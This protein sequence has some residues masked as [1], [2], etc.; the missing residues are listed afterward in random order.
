VLLDRLIQWDKQL[1]LAV[2][3]LHA[4]W[5]D[6]VMFLISNMVFWLPLYFLLIY[7]L[8]RAFRHKAWIILIGLVITLLLCNLLTGELIKPLFA[9]LRPSH[10]PSLVGMVHLVRGYTGGL[11]GFSSGHAANTVAAAVFVWWSLRVRYPWLGL[12]FV[13]P[14]LVCYSRV[15]LGVHYPSDILA[16]GLLGL[17]SA[18][19]GLV[20]V[21]LIFRWFGHVK[22]AT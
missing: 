12:L 2:N 22:D 8:F 10:E 20:I 1:F 16:G 11:H 3:G 15:Y 17:F 18:V 19:V 5:L 7:L 6:P 13:W 21:K 14:V 4:P 9:R